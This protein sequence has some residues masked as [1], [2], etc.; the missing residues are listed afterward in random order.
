MARIALHPQIGGAVEVADYR[1]EEIDVS[2]ICEGVG[3]TIAEVGGPA[4]IVAVRH[5]N[6]DLETSP[7]PQTVFEAGDLIIAM[8]APTAVERLERIF[9]PPRVQSGIR[10]TIQGI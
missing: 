4:L 1:M 6:G 7:P 8:G 5:P 2:P 9:Q 3:K 10:P